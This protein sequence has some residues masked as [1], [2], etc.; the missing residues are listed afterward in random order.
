MEYLLVILT[1][2]T[3]VVIMGWYIYHR[4]RKKPEPINV[5]FVTAFAGML[6][7]LVAYAINK[8]GMGVPEIYLVNDHIVTSTAF[9]KV[10]MALVIGDVIMVLTLIGTA[11]F[12]RYF[13][14]QLDGIIYSVFISLGFIFFQNALFLMH[15]GTFSFATENFRALFLVPIYFFYAILSGYYFARVIYRRPSSTK[16]LIYDLAC[17]ILYPFVLQVLLVT[18]LIVIN[19]EF[20]FWGTL[21]LFLLLIYL[22]FVLMAYC[23]QRIESHLRRDVSEGRV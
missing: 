9:S 17:F 2:L 18:L 16:L 4:D 22:C 20:P 5:L 7:G 11:I 12:N 21:L 6:G 10:I 8:I 14:E 1:T 19:L 3:P 23:N 15:N 13:D